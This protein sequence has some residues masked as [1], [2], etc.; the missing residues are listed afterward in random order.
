MFGLKTQTATSVLCTLLRV[1][2]LTIAICLYCQCL[3]GQERL[4][5]LTNL[6]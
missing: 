1:S 5:T 4:K 2:G 3:R 6:S